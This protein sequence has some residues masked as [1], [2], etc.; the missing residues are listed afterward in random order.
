MNICVVTPYYQGK[1]RVADAGP[2]QREVADRRGPAHPRLRRLGPGA[3]PGFRGDAHRAGAELSRLRQHAAADRLLQCD[4]RPRCRCDRVPGL[5]QL[6][7]SGPPERALGDRGERAT[8]SGG[9]GADAA[10]AGRHAHDEVSDGGRRRLYRH[11]LSDGIAARVSAPDRLD[12]AGS[13][14]E[15]RKPTSSCGGCCATQGVPIAFVDRPTVA[16]R[17]RH[18]CAL[19]S[20]TR[21]AG[22]PG[23][24][25]CAS[26]YMASAIVRS[27]S[28]GKSSGNEAPGVGET[29]RG[30]APGQIFR[31]LTPRRSGVS[32]GARRRNE[33]TV[34]RAFRDLGKIALVARSRTTPARTS[35]SWPDDPAAPPGRRP[36]RGRPRGHLPRP[37]ELIAL[38][39]P[40]AAKGKRRSRTATPEG[41]CIHG[42]SPS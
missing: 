4:H 20:G 22:P 18:R 32:C 17:T 35:I 23:A 15:R 29:V 40:G 30:I 10:P 38:P 25:S 28:S 5:G 3:D 13:R 34:R 31:A 7:L 1:P 26:I 9:L 8:G 27:P 39:V 41:H 19:R 16:Y 14:T 24:L 33:P 37:R 42:R 36:Q 12:F 11:Q 6:V 21:E 2:C